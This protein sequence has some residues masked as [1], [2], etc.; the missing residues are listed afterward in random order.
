MMSREYLGVLIF[1]I[2]PEVSYIYTNLTLQKKLFIQNIAPHLLVFLFHLFN[3][4]VPS[5]IPE[6]NLP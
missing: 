1:Y 3:R 2:T 6:T 4:I 5:N